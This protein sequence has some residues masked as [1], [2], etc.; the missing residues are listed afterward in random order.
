MR[1]TLSS[2]PT[3]QQIPPANRIITL[4]LHSPLDILRLGD[5]PGVIDVCAFHGSEDLFCLFC[6]PFGHQP[7]GTFGK[8]RNGGIEN[9]DEDELQCKWEAPCYGGMPVVHEAEAVGYPVAHHESENV[10]DHLDDD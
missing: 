4:I 5:D 10:E 8:P 9:E 6:S 2:R 7:S 3:P 1:T